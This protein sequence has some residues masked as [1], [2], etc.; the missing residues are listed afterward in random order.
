MKATQNYLITIIP[1]ILMLAVLPT[2]IMAATQSQSIKIACT[3][4]QA[5][6][7]N[8]PI[9]KEPVN[10]EANKPASSAEV[11]FQKNT[12]EEREIQAKKVLVDVETLYYR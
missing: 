9:A 2:K 6:G 3:I 7:E 12:Q 1:A 4:P 8:V 11:V 5:A 10:N